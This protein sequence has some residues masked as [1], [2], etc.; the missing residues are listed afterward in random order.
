MTQRTG[1]TFDAIWRVPD[2][3][4]ASGRVPGYVGAVRIRGRLEVQA[5]GWMATE[6]GAAPMREDTLF[7]IASVT[8]PIGGALTLGLVEDGMLALEDPIARW[9]PEAARVSSRLRT[10]RSTAHFRSARS[11]SG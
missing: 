11:P 9:L 2:A 3:Y 7:R 4:V 8:K 6:A 1:T 5:G 10:P